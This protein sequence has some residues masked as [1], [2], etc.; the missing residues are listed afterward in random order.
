MSP[1]HQE[2]TEIYLTFSLPPT[3]MKYSA[4]RHSESLSKHSTCGEQNCCIEKR[5]FGEVDPLGVSSETTC[6]YLT[7]WIPW[8]PGILVYPCN[9]RIKKSG[10]VMKNADPG[11]YILTVSPVTQVLTWPFVR[12]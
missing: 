10:A 7:N 3:E 5:N 4:H 1:L 9:M 2:I 12:W 11:V 6:Y 8:S